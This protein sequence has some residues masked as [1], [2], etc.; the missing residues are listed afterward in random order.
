MKV[1]VDQFDSALSIFHLAAKWSHILIYDKEAN[2]GPGN[3]LLVYLDDR[4]RVLRYSRLDRAE[5][6]QAADGM[7]CSGQDSKRAWSAYGRYGEDWEPRGLS[8]RC[9]EVDHEKPGLE[10]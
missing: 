6:L 4:G 1:G 8:K 5:D 3:V 2:D 7:F 9:D 10:T